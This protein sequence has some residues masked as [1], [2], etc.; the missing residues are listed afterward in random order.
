MRWILITLTVANIGYFVWQATSADSAATEANF[1]ASRSG[2]RNDITLL[3]ET[4]QSLLVELEELVT[5]PIVNKS[6]MTGAGA[7]GMTPD[8][9]ENSSPPATE[10]TGG[11]PKADEINSVPD[12]DRCM[13]IGPFVSIYDGQNVVNQLASLEISLRVRAV[14]Q[15]TG[16][17]D[18]RLLIPPLNSLEEAFR[19]LRELQ[20]SNIDSYVITAG[21]YALGI[22]LGVFSTRQGAISAS[23]IIRNE[24]FDGDI[25][26]IP[27]MNRTFWLFGDRGKQLAINETVWQ[28]LQVNNPAIQ[29]RELPCE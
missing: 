17:Y 22:S 16:G 28:N 7:A 11:T 1:A 20:A 29:I 8:G 6:S 27:R 15:P 13:A 12:S 23:A 3:S 19:K 26:E 14:D 4:D 21:E 2:L 9:N 18:Y 5:S 25:V 24:G 10:I